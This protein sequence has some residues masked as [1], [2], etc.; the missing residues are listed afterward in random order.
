MR[1]GETVDQITTR[2][3]TAPYQQLRMGKIRHLE[4]FAAMRASDGLE[5]LHLTVKR[6][7]L[8]GIQEWPVSDGFEVHPFPMRNPSGNSIDS[9]MLVLQLTHARY[10]E[11]F[12][13]LCEDICSLLE[14]AESETSAVTL[15]HAR[16]IRWQAFLKQHPP[17]GLSKEAQVGLFGELL[18]LRDTFLPSVVHELAV[19]A[20]RGCKGAHQ[21]FQFEKRALEVKTTRAA[22]VGEVWITNV[23]QLD[24]V[25]LDDLVLSIVHVHANES[26]GETLPAMVESIRSR[27]SGLAAEKFEAGLQTVGYLDGHAEKSYSQTQY[28]LNSIRHFQVRE[29]FPRVLR[30]ELSPGIRSVRYQINIDAIRDFLIAEGPLLASFTGDLNG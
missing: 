3:S 28:H 6:E 26:A 24:D 25:G 19:S 2:G 9:V 7:N 30:A 10:R 13:A 15:F 1:Y 14:S 22:S 12:R 27:L 5:A 29:G 23:Q 17:D 20:W 16:L 4:V 18:I 8:R 21:D 11:V